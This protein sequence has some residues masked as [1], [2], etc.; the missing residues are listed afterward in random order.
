MAQQINLHSPIL[1]APQRAFSARTIGLSLLALTTALGMLGAWMLAGGAALRSDMLAGARVQAVERE[2]LAQALAARRGTGGAALEQERVQLERSL[3]AKR[4]L[5]EELARGRIVEGHSHAAVLRMIS[6]TVP[7]A[8]WLDQIRVA[9]GSLELA[10]MTLQPQALR[11]WLLRLA[12]H[13]LT[14]AQRL[15]TVKLER[16]AP[17]ASGA[18]EPELWAFVLS[19]Q[20]PR[21]KL[22]PA[23]ASIAP[24]GATLAA[25]STQGV[26]R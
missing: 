13:P 15:G 14:Q 16:V 19:S 23:E 7:E 3:Q 2:Q 25:T 18:A 24:A 22:A 21:S 10:G 26:A 5:A 20:V 9:E 11:P 6:L 12:D 4:A 8:V 17:S 1:S